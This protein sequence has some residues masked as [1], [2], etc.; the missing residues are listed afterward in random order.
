VLLT[1]PERY[2]VIFSE[3]SNPYRAGVASLYTREFYQAAA[4]RLRDGGMFLQW[5]Q[6]YEVDA[7]TVRSVI[8]TLTDVFPSVEI[9]LTLS[10]DMLLLGSAVPLERRA[11]ELR[12]R[13]GQEPFRTALAMAWR[14]TDLEGMLAHHVAAPAFCRQ[15]WAGAGQAINTDDRNAVE[16][17]FAR[18]VGAASPF[19]VADLAAAARG[20]GADR[21]AV[22]GEIDWSVVEERRMSMALSHGQVPAAPASFG[23]VERARTAAKAA[24][25]RNDF[26][27]VVRHW[28]TQP[29]PPRDPVELEILAASLAELGDGEAPAAIERLG[30]F[31]SVEA[32]SL[33]ARFHFQRGETAKAA[34][35]LEQALVGYRADPW[36]EESIVARSAELALDIAAADP[37]ER[38]GR[39]L[40]AALAQPFCVHLLEEK[41]QL[42]LL[43]LAES[44][45][46]EKE[47]ALTFAAIQGFEP[48][49]PWNPSFLQKRL[50]VYT[51]IDD[52]RAGAA[53]RDVAASIAGGA[54]PF[55]TYLKAGASSQALAA[56]QQPPPAGR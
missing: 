8:A 54:V 52:A 2:D 37:T 51:G 4:R 43:A 46:G 18:T 30:E 49:V 44:I 20:M 7:S 22:A 14:A 32:A 9:W 19:T 53:K 26:A 42:L 23:P 6:A 36:P 27:A 3:P 1:T 12:R 25:A 21:P 48:H 41:R 29:L 47:G 16:F 15:I 13:I 56:E 24:F 34:E 33:M 31:N 45:E 28:R 39:S 38:L 10:R 55:E 5:L 35:C 17:G 40:Y 11:D 50:R